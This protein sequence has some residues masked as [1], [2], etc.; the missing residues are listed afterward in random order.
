[1]TPEL[2]LNVGY[3]LNFLALVVK[4][5]LI[6]RFMIMTSQVLMI[7]YAQHAHNSVAIFWYSVFILINIIWIILIVLER[8]PIQL[9]G[10]LLHLYQ[11]FFSILTPQEFLKFWNSGEKIIF[12]KGSLIIKE[13]DTKDQIML[14][15]SGEASV[16]KDKKIINNLSRGNFIGEMSYLTHGKATADVLADSPLTVAVWSRKQLDDLAASKPDLWNK[17]Q[18]VIGKDLIK[19]VIDTSAKVGA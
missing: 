3:F 16:C 11:D 14:I 10:E 17:I 8:M 5:I 19:K 2:I 18:S 7:Y 9:H 4:D 13:N 12:G 15:T 1:M 6:L